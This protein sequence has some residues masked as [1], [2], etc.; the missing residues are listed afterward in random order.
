MSVL[1]PTTQIII[2]DL[3]FVISDGSPFEFPAVFTDRQ[4]SGIEL[5][6]RTNDA[7]AEAIEE[8]FKRDKVKIS[9][10]FTNRQ[11]EGK[12][13]L[14][15]SSY[16]N[17]R[18][19]RS[20]RAE[21]KELDTPPDVHELELNGH[22]FEVLKYQEY[23]D[24]D[25]KIDRHALLKLSA[26]ELESFREVAKEDFIAVVRVGV[27]TVPLE[28]ESR[29]MGWWSEHQ[30]GETVFYKQTISLYLPREEEDDSLSYIDRV[31][32]QFRATQR[33]IAGLNNQQ[34]VLLQILAEKGILTQSES[35]QVL[36]YDWQTLDRD[37]FLEEEFVRVR[38]AELYMW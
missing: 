37:D 29:G 30:E 11:Y 33:V 7:M 4:L 14:K 9:D 16:Q 36:N 28:L 10:P 13:T 3:E 1:N 23:S 8:V 19:G 21:V 12:V 6:F 15:S 20:Y 24:K 32:A 5:D 34:K 38:N 18:P 31:H 25:K 35:Q 2:D 22:R 17:N 27:D 26:S